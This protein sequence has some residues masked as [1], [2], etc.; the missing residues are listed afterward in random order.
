M[1]LQE[2]CSEISNCEQC[3]SEGCIWCGSDSGCH[4]QFSP[5]GCMFP[6]TCND[7]ENCMRKSPEELSNKHYAEINPLVTSITLIIAIAVLF[8]LW[9]IMR[10]VINYRK[11]QLKLKRYAIGDVRLEQYLNESLESNQ[12]HPIPFESSNSSISSLSNSSRISIS[13]LRR[14]NQPKLNINQDKIV[15]CSCYLLS[16]FS[17]LIVLFASCIILLF[18]TTPSYY[19]CNSETDWNAIWSS[20]VHGSPQITYDVLFTVKNNNYVSVDLSNIG[21]RLYHNNALIGYYYSSDNLNLKTNDLSVYIPS[22][23]ITDILVPVTFSPAIS[24]AYTIYDLYQKNKL[25]LEI[26]LFADTN[27][28]LFRKKRHIKLFDMHFNLQLRD[29]IVGVNITTDRSE[30]A[31][32][33]H[34]PVAV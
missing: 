9:L 24:Q 32:P 19:S 28:Y 6:V 30:C 34:L 26:D 33:E 4:T 17:I 25:S 11:N 1:S 21:L 8:G 23:S 13:L 12:I 16:C 14:R 15:K 2:S 31:C 22:H 5:Y 18:P 29:Y 20:L 10:F 7:L 3:T 27:A